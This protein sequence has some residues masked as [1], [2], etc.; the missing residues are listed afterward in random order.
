MTK[1]PNKTKGQKV[2]E[3]AAAKRV[4]EGTL[5]KDQIEGYI[6]GWFRKPSSS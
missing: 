4:K 3:A 5:K 1:P 6:R 2:A